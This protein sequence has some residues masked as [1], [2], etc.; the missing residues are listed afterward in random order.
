MRWSG[1]RGR[2]EEGV[3]EAGSG[4]A[5]RA[6]SDGAARLKDEVSDCVAVLRVA[7]RL[8]PLAGGYVRSFPV[9]SLSGGMTR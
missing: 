4:G 5:V 6:G 3:L 7:C 9:G 1:K 8:L 2:R